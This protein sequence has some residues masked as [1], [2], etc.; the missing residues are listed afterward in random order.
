MAGR[1][2][3]ELLRALFARRSDARV[4]IDRHL[5]PSLERRRLAV[6]PLGSPRVTQSSKTRA[7]FRPP[8]ACRGLVPWCTFG[9][10][11]KR[12]SEGSGVGESIGRTLGETTQNDRLETGGHRTAK[13]ERRALGGR[14]DV[15]CA[16]LDDGRSPERWLSREQA[17]CDRTDGIQVLM[18]ADFARRCNRFRRHIKRCS[19]RDLASAC[20]RLRRAQPMH[21]S[22]VEHF[23]DIP[24]PPALAHD[25]VGGLH[26]AMDEPGAMRLVSARQ[27]CSRMNTTRPAGSAPAYV[28]RSSRSP[29][30]RSSIA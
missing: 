30:S 14:M 19:G 15:V 2:R 13:P 7:V 10:T 12:V 9:A 8:C 6:H 24:L 11:A 20:R 25:D 26:V 27:T 29:P 17:V 16:E 23:G 28:T 18:H 3:R 1:V 22:K 21:E 5:G 4:N